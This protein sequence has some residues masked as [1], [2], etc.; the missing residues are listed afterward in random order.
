MKIN[1]I[2][3]TAMI[4]A[5]NDSKKKVTK[6]VAVEKTDSIQISAEARNLSNM[7]MEN[8]QGNSPAKIE[9]IKKQISQGTYKPNSELIA[10]KMMGMIKGSEV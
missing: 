3:Q 4:N 6:N 2:S 8:I 7:S 9:E 5:Y 1:N 10:K